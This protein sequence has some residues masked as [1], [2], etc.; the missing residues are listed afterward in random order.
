M[1]ALAM[2]IMMVGLY[3]IFKYA[4]PTITINHTYKQYVDIPEQ[5][6]SDA[7]EET[8]EGP[9]IASA[10]QEVHAALSVF[11]GGSEDK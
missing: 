1:V 2:L 9:T 10:L 5:K 11:N 6:E 3:G 4:P 7:I 8:P